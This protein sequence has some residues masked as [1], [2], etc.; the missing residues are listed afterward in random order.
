MN[1]NQIRY[2][3][4]KFGKTLTSERHKE[5]NNGS[6]SRNLSLAATEAKHNEFETTDRVVRDSKLQTM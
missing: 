2:K 5:T 6:N 4:N 1:G 3:G